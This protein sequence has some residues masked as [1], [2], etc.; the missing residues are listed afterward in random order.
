MKFGSIVIASLLGCSQ[1]S[2]RLTKIDGSITDI[3]YLE[4]D[5]S[6][7]EEK[8]SYFKGYTPSYDEFP[9]NY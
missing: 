5:S 3:N 8:L 7:I 6:K 4:T 1:A 9:G 2:V